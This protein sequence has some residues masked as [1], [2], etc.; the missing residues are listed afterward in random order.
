MS[1]NRYAITLTDELF[2]FSWDC[3]LI[4]YLVDD[5]S[6]RILLPNWP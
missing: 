2:F 3:S 1:G 5:K 4:L 6:F